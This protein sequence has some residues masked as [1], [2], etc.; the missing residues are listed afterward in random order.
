MAKGFRSRTLFGNH[1][2][3]CF[4][5]IWRHLQSEVERLNAILELESATD[6]R[7]N[8]NFARTHQGQLPFYV[9]IKGKEVVFSAI[10]SEANRSP[11]RLTQP[12]PSP[13]VRWPQ[14]ASSKSCDA[15]QSRTLL[16]TKVCLKTGRID[17]CSMPYRVAGSS[18]AGCKVGYRADWQAILKPQ[19]MPIFTDAFSFHS[20]FYGVQLG[21]SVKNASFVSAS[22]FL[23]LA[24]T[25]PA[26]GAA[27]FPRW[28][29]D[30]P[31][32]DSGALDDFARRKAKNSGTQNAFL[33]TL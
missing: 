6:Q 24:Q 11:Y 1:L 2:N 29:S 7:L 23:T 15:I 5:A 31:G 17:S 10:Y 12:N 9:T 27:A 8:V 18:P 33:H 3:L 16:T 21:L 22:L 26:L 4:H 20:R 32:L 19:Q 28:H 14:R 30:A 13:L 25:G